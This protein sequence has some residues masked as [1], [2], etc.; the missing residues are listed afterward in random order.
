MKRIALYL[1]IALL[2][3]GITP[4]G[5]QS[6]VVNI[7]AYPGSDHGREVND[8]FASAGGSS[9]SP[10]ASYT[11]VISP[12]QVLSY[13]VPIEIPNASCSLGASSH[14]SGGA[15]PCITAPVLD[16]QGS[17][18]NYTGSGDAIIVHGANASGPAQTGAIRNCTVV[19]GSAHASGV[20]LIHIKGRLGFTLS[21]DTLSGGQYCLDWENTNTDGGPGYSEENNFEHIESNR[22]TEHIRTHVGTGGTPSFEYNKLDDWHFTLQNYNGEEHGLSLDTGA[23]A[24]DMQGS[25]MDLKTNSQGTTGASDPL[26]ALIWLAGGN[27]IT[28]SH[29][30]LH[31]EN[32]AGLAHAYSIYNAGG[33]FYAEG[34]NEITGYGLNGGRTVTHPGLTDVSNDIESGRFM[35]METE[36][37]PGGAVQRQCKFDFS[38]NARFWLSSYGGGENDCQF[39]VVARNT[40]NTNLDVY[41]AGSGAPPVNILY[42]DP[43]TKSVGI[44][45]GVGAY[46]ATGTNQLR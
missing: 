38:N 26:V 20:A 36:Q 15:A 33:V 25:V 9:A 7:S 40:D 44:G 22:C 16:C 39:Q 42:T 10:R 28:R 6:G 21:G 30:N 46:S 1:T 18:L 45:A 24:L 31:G 34:N 27:S 23:S 32:T 2:L 35:H 13:G 19:Y 12:G 14:Y 41:H 17:V 29:V 4:A 43:V 3:S 37:D 5:A 8:A 11:V